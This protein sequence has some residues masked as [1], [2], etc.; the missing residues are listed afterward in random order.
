M[1]ILHVIREPN[2]SEK[3]LISTALNY[4]M[5]NSNKQVTVSHLMKAAGVSRATF[6]KYFASKEDLFAAILLQ[7]E[8]ELTPILSRLRVYGSLPDLLESYLSFRVQHI[9]RYRILVGVEKELN[10]STELPRY[11]QWLQLRRQHV[12]EFTRIVRSKLAKSQD[13]D[14]ENL[15]FYYGL[16]WT[17]ATGVAHLSE[18]DFFHQLIVDR[19]GFVKFLL[20]TVNLVGSRK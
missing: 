8:H 1:T 19:R 4:L 16:V 13:I 5:K 12:D 17:L 20:E 11:Q 15:R 7:D 18:Q 6:Y 14:E 10:R 2:P 3:A 9:D